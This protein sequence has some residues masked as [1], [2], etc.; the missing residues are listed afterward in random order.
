MAIS[1]TNIETDRNISYSLNNYIYIM[2][3]AFGIH[4]LLDWHRIKFLWKST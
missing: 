1:I 2:K 3:I 4:L